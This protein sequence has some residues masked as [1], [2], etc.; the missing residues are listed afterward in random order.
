MQRYSAFIY[1]KDRSVGS[2]L[3]AR[4]TIGRRENGECVE[5]EL[6]LTERQRCFDPVLAKSY[7]DTSTRMYGVHYIYLFAKSR[8]PVRGISLSR[9]VLRYLSYVAYR[10]RK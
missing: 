1:T 6:R 2:T 4:Q 7:V 10:N 3:D 9:L 5:T 8:S